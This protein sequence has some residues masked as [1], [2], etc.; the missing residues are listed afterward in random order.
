MVKKL[1]LK[2][3]VVEKIYIMSK[4]GDAVHETGASYCPEK[5]TATKLLLYR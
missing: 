5:A 1:L 3:F 2:L 4:R